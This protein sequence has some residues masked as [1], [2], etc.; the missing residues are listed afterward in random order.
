M[1]EHFWAGM[2]IILLAGVLNGSFP[3]P[4]KYT[5]AWRWENNWLVF[6]AVSLLLLPWL[7]AIIFVTNLSGFYAT[8]P[9]RLLFFPILFGFVWG[10]AQFAFGLGLE[11]LGMALAFPIVAGLVALIGSLV[12]LL[13]ISPADLFRARGILLMVSIPILLVGLVFYSKAGRRREGEKA[14]ASAL[15]SAAKMSFGVG[16]AITIFGGVFGPFWN[17][18]FALSGDIIRKS[19]EWGGSPVTANYPVWAP[20]LTAG[21]VPNLLYCAY[22]LSKNKTWR[23]FGAPG[24]LRETGLA[25]AMALLWLSGIVTYGIGANMV[26][27]YGTSVGFALFASVLVLTSNTLGILAGEWKGVSAGTR[28]LLTYGMGV[29]VVAVIVLSLGGLF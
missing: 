25:V 4:M 14:P 20:V 10:F 3:L 17:L 15:A 11:A 16:L 27:K 23:L 8:L 19:L 28:R 7:L 13:I 9:G 29:I 5:R 24:S 26:G 21:F 12:P 18:G 1:A 6:T 22:L 2:A